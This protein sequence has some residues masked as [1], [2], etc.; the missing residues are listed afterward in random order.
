MDGELGAAGESGIGTVFQL[1][2]ELFACMDGEISH[3]EAGSASLDL[4]R[5]ISMTQARQCRLAPLTQVIPDPSL[6][7][8]HPMEVQLWCDGEQGP[9]MRAFALVE[10]VSRTAVVIS[11]EEES[12]LEPEPESQPLLI[13]EPSIVAWSL[14]G[15]V[16]LPEEGEGVGGGR[17]KVGGQRQV[18]LLVYT[19]Y[20][21]RA[22]NLVPLGSCKG[23][24][25]Q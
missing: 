16:L 7:V 4:T 1:I 15:G 23:I 13:P 19:V 3:F 20:H 17:G 9:H 10:H 12:E 18:P 24:S 25:F 22:D 21:I 14:E 6:R 8:S 2:V 11:G 5:A